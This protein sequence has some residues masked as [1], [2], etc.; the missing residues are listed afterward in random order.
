MFLEYTTTLTPGNPHGY[1]ALACSGGKRYDIG[2]ILTP[3]IC[4][5][6]AHTS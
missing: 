2:A 5:Q 1:T 3:G 6:H 4:H